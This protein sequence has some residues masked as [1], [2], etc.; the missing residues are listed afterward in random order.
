MRASALSCAARSWNV[1]R[2]RFGPPT[3]RACS[4]IARASMPCADASATTSPVVAS[5]SITGV[6]DPARHSPATKLRICME[7][8]RRLRGLRLLR[9]VVQL[10]LRGQRLRLTRENESLLELPIF[11]SIVDSHFHAAAHEPRAAGRAHAG[12]A[13]E[14]QLESCPGRALENRL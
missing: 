8:L 9:V 2:R 11:E 6:P 12:A 3:P 4:S 7:C 5:R 13:G 10:E 14:G 1:S